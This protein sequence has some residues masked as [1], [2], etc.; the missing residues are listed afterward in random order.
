MQSLLHIVQSLHVAGLLSVAVWVAALVFVS[1]PVKTRWRTVRF[2]QCLGLLLVSFWLADLRFM[3]I[4][5]LRVDQR[6]ELAE[7]EERLETRTAAKEAAAARAAAAEAG[8]E[9][10]DAVYE[11]AAAGVTEEEV[12]HYRSRGK[13]ERE[14]GKRVEDKTIA[15]MEKKTEQK[16]EASSKLYRANEIHRMKRWAR[17]NRRWTVL[18]LWTL[19]AVTAVDYLRRLNTAADAYLPV[20]I[21]GRWLWFL[22]RPALR[23]E[24]TPAAADAVRPWLESVV[25]KGET[26]IYFGRRDPW[27][28]AAGPDRATWH[29]VDRRAALPQLVIPVPRDRVTLEFLPLRRVAARGAPH[30]ETMDDTFES[31]WF[32]RYCFVV[33]PD[34]S[35]GAWLAQLRDFL[36]RRAVV[37]A[38]ARRPMNLVWDVPGALDDDALNDLL[39]MC[40]EI[41]CRL[42]VFE[43][44]RTGGG[45][46][47]FDERLSIPS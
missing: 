26:F 35:A 22:G 43:A 40:G 3:Q 10:P 13:V 17:G 34:G 31:A 44:S 19:A 25:R 41:N 21:C 39:F 23:V 24:A 46:A 33:V 1:R 38:S 12:R 6:R 14:E 27:D 30:A 18:L 9:D 2:W 4:S 28:P 20:P 16:I 42:V 47:D 5:R 7:A 32:R 37:L 11:A 29:E 15:A 45:E 8:A 36:H